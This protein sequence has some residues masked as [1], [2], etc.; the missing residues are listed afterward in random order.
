MDKDTGRRPRISI[1]IDED[2]QVRL[3][4]L[5]PWGLQSSIFRTIAEGLLDLMEKSPVQRDLVIAAFLSKD[6]TILD[7]MKRMVSNEPK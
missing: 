6:I 3:Q 1:E 2:T 5:I 4:K 7:L